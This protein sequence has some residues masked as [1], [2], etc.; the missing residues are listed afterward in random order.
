[1]EDVW[2]TPSESTVPRWL[3]NVDIRNGIRAMQKVDRCT[4]EAV[5]LC[6][7]ANN[8]CLWFAAEATAVRQALAAPRSEL[9]LRT[10][11]I[12]SLV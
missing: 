1:M 6:R 9:S 7:E 4:E 2:I 10:Y 3:E 8:M 12:Y 11:T 5:R